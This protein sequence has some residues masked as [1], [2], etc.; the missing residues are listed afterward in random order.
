MGD[1][2]VTFITDSIE[3]AIRMLNSFAVST[4]CRMQFR[5]LKVHTGYGVL[6]ELVPL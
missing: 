5:V 3:P 1:G 2:A 6:W 4:V